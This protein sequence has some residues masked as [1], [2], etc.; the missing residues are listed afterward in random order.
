MPSQTTAK[1]EK[2][3]CEVLKA[4]GVD[5]DEATLKIG[6]ER[7][8]R[9]DIKFDPSGLTTMLYPEKDHYTDN[10]KTLIKAKPVYA[11]LDKEVAK[12]LQTAKAVQIVIE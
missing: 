12:K 3:K 7:A 8:R 6:K 5:A 1:S 2:I 9:K 11:Y 10:G 4:I